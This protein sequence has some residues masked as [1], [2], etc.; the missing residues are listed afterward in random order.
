[1]HLV[2]N[3]FEAFNL[4]SSLMNNIMKSIKYLML[5]WSR[6]AS[7][8][9]REE[10]LTG[11]RCWAES[12]REVV[13]ALRLNNIMLSGDDADILVAEELVESRSVESKSVGIGSVCWL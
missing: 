9:P 2:A 13:E 10:R 7:I 12:R 3:K 4:K 8:D 11:V 1:M 6:R 5:P